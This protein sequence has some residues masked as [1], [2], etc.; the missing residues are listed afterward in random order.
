MAFFLFIN[1]Y[2]YGSVGGPTIWPPLAAAVDLGWFVCL[3]A[4]RKY[5]PRQ[6]Q[7]VVTYALY[8]TAIP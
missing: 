4:T 1:F 7:L 2:R 6:E 3:A 5:L 8:S